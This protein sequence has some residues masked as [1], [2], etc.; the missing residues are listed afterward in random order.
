[1]GSLACPHWGRGTIKTKSSHPGL[2]AK[3]R[4]TLFVSGEQGKRSLNQLKTAIKWIRGGDLVSHAKLNQP[5]TG[6]ASTGPLGTQG[7]S[8]REEHKLLSADR[9]TSRK[10]CIRDWGCPGL[11]RGLYTG[12]LS[13]SLVPSRAEGRRVGGVKFRDWGLEAFEKPLN[14]GPR[15]SSIGSEE[16]FTTNVGEI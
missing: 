13:L 16:A 7:I 6:G 15:N 1:V 5:R 11:G 8:I 12:S 2:Q 10:G 9:N 14:G 3:G 4:D